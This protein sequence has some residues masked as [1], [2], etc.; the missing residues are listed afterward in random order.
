MKC[1]LLA[2]ALV[3][4]AIAAPGD[5]RAQGDAPLALGGGSSNQVSPRDL[6][7]QAAAAAREGD[8]DTAT[9]RTGDLLATGR[10][11]GIKTFPQYA[12]SASGWASQVEKNNQALAVWA[13]KTAGQLDGGSPA[14]AFSEA[15]RAGRKEAWGQALPLVLRGFTRVMRDYRSNLLSRADLFILGALAIVLTTILLAL[16]L[17]IRYGRAMAHDFRERLSSR[18][19]GGSVSVLAFALLFLPIFLWLGP[20]W[21]LFYWLAIFFPYAAIGERIAIGVLLVLIALLPIAADYNATRVAAVESPVVLAALS[22]ENQAYQPEALRRL[23]ELIAVVPDHPVLHVLAG[24]MQ[25]FEGNEEQAQQHYNRAVELRPNYAGAHVNL[26]N[27]LF[28]NNEFQAAM[29]AYEKAQQAD[30]KL[31]AAFYN[32]SVASGET[33]KFDQQARMLESARKAN[34]AFVERVTQVAPLQKIV[35][36]SPPLDEAWDI[37]AELAKRP[38]AR[39]LFGNYASFDLGRSAVN[40]LTI[41]ALLSLL[42]ALVL[43][44]RRRKTGLANSCIKCGR[45][46]CPRCKSAREST[47]YCTQCI[48][49]Y[50][51]RDGVSID[52]KRKKLEEVTAHQTGMVRRNKLF[53]T[54]LPGAAQMLEGRIGAGVVGSFLFGLFV[55][56]ALLIGRLAPAIG[57]AADTAQLMVR[58]VAIVLAAVVWIVFALPVY[59]RRSV[60]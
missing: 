60:A 43:W 59:R 31:A 37:T 12:A 46:F 22:S 58:I 26:G 8:F 53:A 48:H 17:F 29:T 33:Y 38:A 20:I 32:H 9:K 49:I 52:T 5:V 14:T 27:L 36:Y 51:K 2:V 40:P 16:A 23:Q 56:M 34:P 3:L 44:T 45:T 55:A 18:F 6:W 15:D 30:P 47:T 1:R 7:P 10:T 24:N 54:F 41:G 11:Y 13:A 57:P 28:M 19:T 39:A 21:L 25:S 42:L 4:A 35:M 50:L